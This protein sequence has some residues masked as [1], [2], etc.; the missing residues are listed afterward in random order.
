M[1]DPSGSARDQLFGGSHVNSRAWVS[2]LPGAGDILIDLKAG[3]L[4][5]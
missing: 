3:I 2:S 4:E 5:F 1:T